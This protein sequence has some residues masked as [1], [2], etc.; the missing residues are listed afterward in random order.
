MAP[1]AVNAERVYN[2]EHKLT[3]FGF[4]D[5]QARTLVLTAASLRSIRQK[6]NYSDISQV[7]HAAWQV[8]DEMVRA[9]FDQ[10]HARKFGM[11]FVAL[12]GCK[13]DRIFNCNDYWSFWEVAAASEV[14]SCLEATSKKRRDGYELAKTMLTFAIQ[15][16]KS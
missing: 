9:G 2:L 13:E 3:N 11:M 10:Q 15:E 7:F 12:A 6:V 16:W 1:P 5:Q 4:T 14:C 8:E